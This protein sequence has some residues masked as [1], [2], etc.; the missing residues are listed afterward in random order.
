MVMRGNEFWKPKDNQTHALRS[1]VS[2]HAPINVERSNEGEWVLNFPIP[3]QYYL[4]NTREGK[5]VMSVSI[6]CW[7]GGRNNMMLW[8]NNQVWY[9]YTSLSYLTYFQHTFT[10]YLLRAQDCTGRLRPS[11]RHLGTNWA[12]LR[13]VTKTDLNTSTVIKYWVPIATLKRQRPRSHH[14]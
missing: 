13:I 11:L 6:I 12:S 4:N 7:R 1:L 5:G 10:T 8:Q 3:L 9:P 2:H 14:Y